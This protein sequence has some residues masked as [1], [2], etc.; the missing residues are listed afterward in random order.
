ML[1]HW[2]YAAVSTK[3]K[4][5]HNS[6]PL[7]VISQNSKRDTE[8]YL[9]NLVS[10]SSKILNYVTLTH[11]LVCNGMIAQYIQLHLFIIKW[12]D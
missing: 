1:Q 2:N 4:L 10:E 3:N 12:L 8:P 7:Y 6:N 11:I 5:Q 9:K